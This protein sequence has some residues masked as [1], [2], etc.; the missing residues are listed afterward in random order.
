MAQRVVWSPQAIADV[1][2]IGVWVHGKRILHT[3]LLE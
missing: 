1:E 2:A 3:E